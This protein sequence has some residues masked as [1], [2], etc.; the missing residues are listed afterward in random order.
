LF[1]VLLVIAPP[2][3]KLEPP[4]NPGRFMTD[5]SEDLEERRVAELLEMDKDEDEAT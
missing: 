3:Q 1:V 2:S 5:F 4:T